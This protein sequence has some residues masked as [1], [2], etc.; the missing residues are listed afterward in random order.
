LAPL[1]HIMAVGTVKWFNPHKGFGFIQ[2]DTGCADDTLGLDEVAASRFPAMA[3]VT[4]WSC[5]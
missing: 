4:Q 3:T 2:P 5:F 1:E